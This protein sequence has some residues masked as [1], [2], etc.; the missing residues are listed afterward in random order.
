MFRGCWR[1]D[2]EAENAAM[3]IF[4]GVLIAIPIWACA[5]AA[6]VVI[7]GGR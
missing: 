2:P 6:I 5:L 3:G 7:G 4:V 1:A